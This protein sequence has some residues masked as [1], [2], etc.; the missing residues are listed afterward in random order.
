[1]AIPRESA[2]A[3]ARAGEGTHR[4]VLA[5]F[6]AVVG[7]AW[8]VWLGAH[9]AIPL[10]PDG[11]PMTLQSLAV[12]ITALTLRPSLGVAAM[13]FYIFV[14]ALGAGAFAEGN[15]GI[16]TVLGQTGGYLVGFVVCQPVVNAIVRRPGGEVRGWLA[17]IAAVLAGNAV[18]FAIGVPWLAVVHGYGASRALE[19]GFY[20]F[21]P[22]LL[23]KCALA[24]L[25]GRKLAPWATRRVW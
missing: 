12:V 19:G 8:A 2:A 24:V 3:P 9:I 22:G 25:I 11:V 23:L 7:A 4:G 15:K 1:M 17:L 6:A 10:P 20:P 16:E 21:L 13:L 18:I 14:G 5:R